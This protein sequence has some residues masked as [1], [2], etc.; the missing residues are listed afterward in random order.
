MEMERLTQNCSPLL[1][2]EGKDVAVP[3]IPRTLYMLV[4]S[5]FKIQDKVDWVVVAL[6]LSR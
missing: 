1:R 4:Y 3:V 2:D 6:Q 5:V